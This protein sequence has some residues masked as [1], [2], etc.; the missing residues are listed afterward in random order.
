[1][2]IYI[3]SLGS[4]YWDHIE[5]KYTTPTRPLTDDQK[6]EQQENHQALEAIISS[7]SDA[8]YVDVHGLET[9]YEVW[10]KLEE[11]YSSDEH[12]KISKEES[13]RGK[14]DNMRMFEGEN[15]QQYGQRI[16]EIVGEIK[17]A[18]W[19]VEDA[20]VISKVLRTLLLVYAIWVVGIQ[21]LKSIHKTK[22]TLDS[23]IDKLTAFELNDYDGSVQKSESAFRASIS[24]P[25]VRRSRDISHN[26]ESRSSKDVEDEDNLVELEALL[27]KCLPRGTG[28]YRGKLPLKWFACNNIGHIETN[29]PNGENEYKRDKFK[30]YKGKGKRDCL[31]AIDNGI[32]DEES[33]DDASEEIVFV[34]C[35]MQNLSSFKAKESI[36]N[37]GNHESLS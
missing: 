35:G 5:N 4:Q 33:D 37:K 32:I 14:F 36:R 31:V 2:K 16:K 18:G 34:A 23:I 28:K 10:K 30:K 7:L 13:L 21:G 1:M 15:I 26:Y 6:K 11:I 24:N 9:P 17:S 12:V 25:F 29:F 22:V 27:A 3:K 20:I 19:K 8:E